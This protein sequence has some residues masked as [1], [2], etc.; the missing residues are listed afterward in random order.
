MPG[1]RHFATLLSVVGLSASCVTPAPATEHAAVETHDTMT[2][3]IN[4]ASDAIWTIRSDARSDAEGLDPSLMRDADWA[5][6]HEA[7]RSLEI[8]SRR[9]AEAQS[10]RVGAREAETA[11]FASGREIQARIDADPAWFRKTSLELAEH[12]NDLGAAAKDRNARLARDLIE[13][14]GEFCQA[15]HSRYWVK[16]AP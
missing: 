11:G 6:L 12:A 9:M 8:H 14:T 3:W 2:H 16:T 4:R 10:I 1:K 7:A 13:S 15:C 5:Q